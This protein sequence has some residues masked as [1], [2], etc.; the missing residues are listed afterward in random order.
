MVNV[1]WLLDCCTLLVLAVL[2][3]DKA[4][5]VQSLLLSKHT[6]HALTSARIVK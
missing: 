6:Q 1:Q 4:A 3:E 5:W 2:A